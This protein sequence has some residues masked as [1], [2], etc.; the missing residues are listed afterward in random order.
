MVGSDCWGDVGHIDGQVAGLGVEHLEEGRCRGGVWTR[1]TRGKNVN[2]LYK[3]ICNP[4]P[5]TRQCE[6]VR[7]TELSRSPCTWGNRMD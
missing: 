7:R 5:G 6:C 1:G 2:A 4:P 3:L